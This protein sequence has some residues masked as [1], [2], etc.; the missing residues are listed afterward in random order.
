MDFLEY[1]RMRIR[2]DTTRVPVTLKGHKVPERG[3]MPGTGCH[4]PKRLKPILETVYDHELRKIAARRMRRDFA[5]TG[6]PITG[7][8]HPAPLSG[9]RRAQQLDRLRGPPR[10]IVFIRLMLG[11]VLVGSVM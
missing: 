11:G 3:T 9:T 2:K 10:A 4:A 6:A 5:K 8:S 1:G 7:A